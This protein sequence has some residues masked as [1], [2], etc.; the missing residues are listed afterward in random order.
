MTST[1]RS[2]LLGSVG[3]ALVAFGSRSSSSCAF[4]AA[5]QLQGTEDDFRRY[6]PRQTPELELRDYHIHIRGGMTPE[7]AHKRTLATG[8]RSG[9]LENV[10]REWPIHSNELLDA[11]VLDVEKFNATLPVAE[12]LK[13]GIQVND[14]DWYTAIDPK[15]LK[16]LDYVLADT[17]IM[18]NVQ[19]APTNVS[20]S[21]RKITTS[22]KTNGLN[23][24]SS[25]A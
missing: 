10:G 13:I 15:I 2:F 25:I 17:M 9:A 6:A 11:F 21:F 7:L 4:D 20:G 22:I 18:E 12:R 16:R 14:R 8:V 23:V 3:A 1:R 5:L 24:T 19:T